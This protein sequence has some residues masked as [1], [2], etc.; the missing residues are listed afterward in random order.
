MNG[1]LFRGALSLKIQILHLTS[2]IKPVAGRV[3][4]INSA[5][6]ESLSANVMHRICGLHLPVVSTN[7]YNLYFTNTL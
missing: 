3:I 2:I 4:T 5:L 1:S 7:Y 6:S